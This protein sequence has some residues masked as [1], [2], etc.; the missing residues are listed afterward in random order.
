MEDV[1]TNQVLILYYQEIHKNVKHSLKFNL[2]KY[3]DLSF[4]RI[5]YHL[6]QQKHLHLRLHF[7]NNIRI[8]LMVTLVRWE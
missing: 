1:S 5:K 7:V 4:V 3:V 2:N 6:T 8:N